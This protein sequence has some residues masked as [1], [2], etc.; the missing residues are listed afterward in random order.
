MSESNATDH[1]RQA[2]PPRRSAGRVIRG[3]ILILGAAALFVTGIDAIADP[4]SV[5]AGSSNSARSPDTDTEAKI[6]G[7]LLCFFGITVLGFG[8]GLI[9]SKGPLFAKKA[10]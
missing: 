9:V 8:I 1:G 10:E 7:L 5:I 4:D 2:D 6:G 3:I